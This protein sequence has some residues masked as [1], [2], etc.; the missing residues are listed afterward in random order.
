MTITVM[1]G[2]LENLVKLGVSL[3]ILFPLPE[4]LL[5]LRWRASCLLLENRRRGW[6]TAVDG[7]LER[8][9]VIWSGLN[10]RVVFQNE[11]IS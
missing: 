10:S 3:K 8:T 11:A 5:W 7:S 6:L 9:P 4:D 1:D 2:E